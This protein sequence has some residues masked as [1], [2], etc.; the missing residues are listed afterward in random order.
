MKEKT[1]YIS[2]IIICIVIFLI[3]IGISND[4]CVSKNRYLNFYELVL[5][6]LGETYSLLFGMSFVILLLSASNERPVNQMTLKPASTYLKQAGILAALMIILLL[7]ASLVYSLISRGFE[8][9]LENRWSYNSGFSMTGRS[10]IVCLLI[11]VMLF[12]LRCTFLFYFISFINILTRKPYWGFWVVLLICFI[13]FRFY[14]QTHIPYPLNILPVEHTRIL[15]TSA[16]IVP[17]GTVVRVSYFISVLYW[18]IL[19][20]IIYESLHLYIRKEGNY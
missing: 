15:Y 20:L 12:G 10:P 3:F 7:L 2:K 11:A 17:M 8:G 1:G 6:K 14:K 16:F 13:D 9:V 4:I 5:S 19:I 18:I